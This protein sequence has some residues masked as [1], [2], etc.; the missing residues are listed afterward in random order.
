MDRPGTPP[1]VNFGC[2]TANTRTIQTEDAEDV[3]PPVGKYE[4][5]LGEVF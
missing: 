4:G 3:F 5:F 1:T 2:T